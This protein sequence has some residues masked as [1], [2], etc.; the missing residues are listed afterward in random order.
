MITNAQI[1]NA[2]NDTPA[3]GSN[4]GAGSLALAPV[5]SS[6]SS[7]PGANSAAIAARVAASRT[8][9]VLVSFPISIQATGVPQQVP[10]YVVPDGYQVRIR[11]NNGTIGSNAAMLFVAQYYDAFAAGHASPVNQFDDLQ[12]Q[13]NNTGSLWIKGTQGDGIVL[14]IVKVI[15][16]V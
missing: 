5:A 12:F 15:S 3:R 8:S 9:V 4:P 16:G 7:G 14:T 10:A 11:A 1:R 13:V 2:E 6:S